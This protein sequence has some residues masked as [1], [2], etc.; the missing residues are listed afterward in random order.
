[1]SIRYSGLDAADLCVSSSEAL[2]PLL[3]RVTLPSGEHKE[4]EHCARWKSSDILA[5]HWLV[6]FHGNIRVSGVSLDVTVQSS[7]M[8]LLRACFY[9]REM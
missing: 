5:V 2:S 8:V 1:M 9:T 7:A 4:G 3:V 6:C